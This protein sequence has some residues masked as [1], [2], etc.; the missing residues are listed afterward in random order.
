MSNTTSPRGVI[1]IMSDEHNPKVMG[2]SGHPVIQT[3]HLDALAARGTRFT[4]AYT[5]S[6][7]CVPARAA[8]AIGKNIHQ[9]G[10]WDNADAYD[11][12]V[13][14]WHHALRE[15]GHA[16]VSIGKLHFNLKDED[17]GFSRRADPDAHPR[18]QGRPDG[19]G[20]RRPAAPRRC[21]ED[22]RNGRARRIVVHVLRPRHLRPS[23][24]LAAAKTL[25]V[26]MPS[27]GCCSCPSSRR[28][29]R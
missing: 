9:I 17:H 11:G 19:L 24:G 18:R 4:S 15:R 12:S 5:T 13:P 10:Y 28:T 26:P 29:F 8:F 6:P 23:P 7:V 14:S 2:C 22:G 21:Q 16:V 3:P 27:P 25:L 20:A 1:V